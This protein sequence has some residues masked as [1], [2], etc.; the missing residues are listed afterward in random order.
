MPEQ[1]S[2]LRVA[3]ELRRRIT[4][5]VWEP[6][7][8]LPPR[9]QIGQEFGVGENVVRRAQ[10]LLISQGKLKGRAGSGMY[11]A[12]PQQ[13]MRVARSPAREQPDGSQFRAD[14]RS[15]TSWATGR[16]VPMRRCR[17]CG[18]GGA[19]RHRRGRPACS[20]VVQ[21]PRRQP[22][23]CRCRQV[24]NGTTSIRARLSSSPRVDRTPEGVVNRM[25]V[26]GITASHAVERSQPRQATAEEVSLLE[27]QKAA[28]ITHTR[29]TYYSDQGRP[30][31]GGHRGARRSLR[32]RL[33]DSDQS[34]AVSSVARR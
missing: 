13:R 2:D 7:A 6:A 16:A 5:H 17:P 20:D 8:R 33:R 15:S 21:V 28:L 25:V 27:I 24:G 11:V 9:A 22:G 32:D 3:H 4:E 1:P 14:M 10:E 29:R 18:H 23:G 31:D 12:D 19:A 26:V 34:L 30:V